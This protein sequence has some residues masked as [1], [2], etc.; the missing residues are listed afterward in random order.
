MRGRIG[1]G[2]TSEP[3]RTPWLMVLPAMLLLLGINIVP[4]L[5]STVLSLFQWNLTQASV[6]PRF[7]GLDNFVRLL[8]QDSQFLSASLNT[9]ILVVSAV[10]L[11]LVLGLAIA[12][13]LDQKLRFSGVA[14]TLLLIPLALAP[15]VVGLLFSSLLSD[16]L[17]PVNY[18]LD[19]AGIPSPSWL[20][21][22][23][24]SLAT[25]VL[26]DTWQWT[27]F[28][29]LLIL[30]GFRSLPSEPLEAAVVDGAGS[31]QRFR[32]VKLPMLAP[33]LMVAG[34]LRAIDAFKT[35][36]LVFLLTFGGPGTSSTS[37]SFYGYKVGLQSFDIGRASAISF[38]MVN[39]FAVLVVF[40]YWRAKD[41]L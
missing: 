29:V 18:L 36:D 21:D 25:I 3:R 37:V 32:F 16:S 38:L 30:A 35:F 9:L 7:V 1:Q 20:G 14:T 17:G 34:L 19:V 13:L 22:P 39:V 12:T 5:Y 33:V 41:Q 28:M 2:A 6:S 40:F 8:T 27:P 10:G 26:V 23:R 31:W 11:Q 24:W 4:V 15:A